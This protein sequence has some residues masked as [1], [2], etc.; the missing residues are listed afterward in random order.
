V[1]QKIQELT[2]LL[3]QNLRKENISVLFQAESFHITLFRP[4]SVIG[5]FIEDE[6]L[7]TKIST[8]SL[9][10]APINSIVLCDRKSAQGEF[11]KIELSFPL[12]QENKK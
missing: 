4:V 2:S 3:V 11:Y 7:Q 6:E 10:P 12:M 9:P 5:S 8:F 1:F